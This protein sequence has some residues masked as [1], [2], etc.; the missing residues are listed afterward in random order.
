M[1]KINCQAVQYLVVYQLWTTLV[2]YSTKTFLS[3]AG[4]EHSGQAG[5]SPNPLFRFIGEGRTLYVALMMKISPCPRALTMWC[6]SS[7][8]LPTL[9]SF[10]IFL[11]I[12]PSPISQIS[13][14][15][16]F[17]S[18]PV[19]SIQLDLPFAIKVS[20]HSNQS[21][22]CPALDMNRYVLMSECS[23]CIQYCSC[24]GPFSPS[25]TLMSKY[26]DSVSI[27]CSLVF[28]HKARD[29]QLKMP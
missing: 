19:A 2:L 15:G 4:T 13:L 1:L 25:G 23:F 5:S 8:C 21:H 14:D 20:F 26:W 11:G 27:I 17:L 10:P 22:L 7:W 9:S 16:A 28:L 6:S 29:L 3:V 12:M 24:W 18:P